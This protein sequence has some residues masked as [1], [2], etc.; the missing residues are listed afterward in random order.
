VNGLGYAAF[1]TGAVLLASPNRHA[2]DEISLDALCI[3]LALITTTIHAQDF[4]DV[5]GDVKAGRTTLPMILQ[6][7]LARASFAHA[8]D[9]LVD[10]IDEDVEG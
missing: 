6:P 4:K 3:S 2:L 5:E 7:S 9:G 10:L 1:A 8:H